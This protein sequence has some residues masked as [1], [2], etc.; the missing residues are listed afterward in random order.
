MIQNPLIIEKI[1]EKT[2]DND[3]MY[4]FI[5]SIMTNESEGKQFSKFFK[6]EIEKYSKIEKLTEDK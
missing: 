6:A 2:K 4:C 3:A 5:E 1:A